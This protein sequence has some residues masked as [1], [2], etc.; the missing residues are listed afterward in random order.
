[1]EVAVF[2]GTS[3]VLVGSSPL[4]GAGDI[5]TVGSLPLAGA[6]EISTVVSVAETQTDSQESGG[7]V[8][9][10]GVFPLKCDDGDPKRR[11][12]EAEDDLLLGGGVEQSLLIS[13]SCPIGSQT[14]DRCSPPSETC[15]A[16]L[17]R[18][19]DPRSVIHARIL[20]VLPVASGLI[21]SM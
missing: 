5:S 17:W 13:S 3:M 9:V 2:E 4:A 12:Q 15:D 14:M 21:E 19:R 16:S 18:S 10:L 6:G 20:A 11:K 8:L 7:W 1:M